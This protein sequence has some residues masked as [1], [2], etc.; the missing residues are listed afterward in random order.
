MQLKNPFLDNRQQLPHKL[1][2][3]IFQTP[4]DNNLTPGQTPEKH[5]IKYNKMQDHQTIDQV[6]QYQI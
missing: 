4:I 5:I 3:I 1:P 2:D 6:E